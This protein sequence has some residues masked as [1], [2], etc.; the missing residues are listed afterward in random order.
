[1]RYGDGLNRI[2]CMLRCKRLQQTKGRNCQYWEYASWRNDRVCL[3]MNAPS[4]AANRDARHFH[5]RGLR[6]CIRATVGD[7]ACTA[8]AIHDADP[9]NAQ[10]STRLVA[11]WNARMSVGGF[12]RCPTRRSSACSQSRSARAVGFAPAAARAQAATN[13]T[14]ESTTA[15]S[16][17]G[18]VRTATSVPP[19]FQTLAFK[20]S[21]G[22]NTP[23]NRA[24]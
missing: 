22:N 15:S 5:S 1:M 13:S 7:L 9:S 6:N 20:V 12:G 23:A 18:A 11:H 17:L 14:P 8:P 10:P 2:P 4:V 21:P 24:P 3:M 16:R 19:S